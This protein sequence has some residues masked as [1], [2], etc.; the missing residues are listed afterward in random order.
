MLTNAIKHGRNGGH[1]AIAHLWEA[2][3]YTVSVTNLLR[4]EPNQSQA[5]TPLPPKAQAWTASAPGCKRPC[6]A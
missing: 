6:H 2:T 1:I 5:P 3:A 4:E